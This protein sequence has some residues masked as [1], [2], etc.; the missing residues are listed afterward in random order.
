MK[1]SLLLV[2]VAILTGVFVFSSCQK[3]ETIKIGYS[4]TLSGLNSD[5][6]IS[7]R[8]GAFMAVE[9]INATGGIN[10]KML[11][12]IIKDDK[13]D[14]K[15]ALQVDQEFYEAGVIAIVGH[16]T[17]SMADLTVPYINEKKLL[18]LSP[19]IAAEALS[20]KDDY[21]FR[22]IPSN[23]EQAIEIS[24]AMH[25]ENVSK[26]AIIFDASNL[27]F[28]QGLKKQFKDIYLKEGN[29]IVLEK[30]FSPAEVDYMEMSKEILNSGAEG[31]FIIGGSNSVAMLSQN[32]YKQGGKVK[33]FLPSWAMTTDLLNHG[34]KSMEE[35]C[36]VNFYDNE[37]QDPNYQNFKKD[38]VRNFGLEPGFSAQFSYE[39]VMVLAAA[40]NNLD[41]YSSDSLKKYMIQEESFQGLQG[42]ISFNDFGD[43]D[44]EKYIF[45]V[46]DG[47]FVIISKGGIS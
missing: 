21:F 29:M 20:N 16:M 46:K 9:K 14:S 33:I 7:G 15:R 5:L 41:D 10:G 22:M 35:A 19:T 8:N 28:T 45:K 43:V 18:M 30:A 4:G 3:N 37:S 11:E 31:V 39:A 38:Y 34:G 23:L 1:R 27:T 36:L 13:N 12:I 6:G 42:K 17:S 32:F 2:S 24:K 25:M 40:M 26:A 44:R 47:K